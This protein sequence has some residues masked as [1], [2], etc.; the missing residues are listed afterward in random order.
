[1]IKKII[2]LFLPLFLISCAGKIDQPYSAS[3]KTGY[4]TIQ[5]SETKFRISVYGD[6]GD[7]LIDLNEIA[8]KQAAQKTLSKKYDY[9]SVLSAS[10]IKITQEIRTTYDDATRSS[11][12]NTN[13]YRMIAII[14][15]MKK[16]TKSDAK[17]DFDP[18]NPASFRIEQYK[19][20]E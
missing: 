10:P 18:N 9:F 2:L 15:E 5:M 6:R 7:A 19:E 4:K 3:S 12:S 11:Y 16:G 1:M 17:Y 20:G 8:L 13:S 14:F